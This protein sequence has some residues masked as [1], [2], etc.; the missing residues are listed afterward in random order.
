MNFGWDISEVYRTISGQWLN[1]CLAFCL[2]ALPTGP[3]QLHPTS[4]Q[5]WKPLRIGLCQFGTRILGVPLPRVCRRLKARALWL[6]WTSW[7]A[8]QLYNL[9]VHEFV[10]VCFISFHSYNLAALRVE[11]NPRFLN[12]VRYHLRCI[13]ACKYIEY[14]IYYINIY[15]YEIDILYR[16]CFIMKYINIL[17]ITSAF[18]YIFC[19]WKSLVKCPEAHSLR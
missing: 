12:A 7:M 15:Y 18:W 8:S 6:F 10:Y 13:S 16:F 4:I 3:M 5:I 17:H 14:C 11:A 19:L 9:Y 2:N 1:K